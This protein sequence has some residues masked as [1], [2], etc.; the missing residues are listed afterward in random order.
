MLFVSYDIQGSSTNEDTYSLKRT[1]NIFE[2]DNS[3]LADP[4]LLVK[5]EAK[6][7]K[8]PILEKEE[9]KPKNPNILYKGIAL[10]I[11]VILILSLTRQFL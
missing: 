6:R 11:L 7:K 4:N 8:S 9:N 5:K 3:N 1:E 10:I 2:K